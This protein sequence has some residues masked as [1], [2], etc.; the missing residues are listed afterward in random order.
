MPLETPAVSDFDWRVTPLSPGDSPHRYR[1]LYAFAATNLNLATMLW[2]IANYLCDPGD[3]ETRNLAAE[4]IYAGTLEPIS[5]PDRDGVTALR[6]SMHAA[7]ALFTI[8]HQ[9]ATRSR[10]LARRS[11]RFPRYFITRRVEDRLFRSDYGDFLEEEV[12]PGAMAI[13]AGALQLRDQALGALRPPATEVEQT[14]APTGVEL[15]LRGSPE[16]VAQQLAGGEEPERRAIIAWLDDQRTLSYRL[17]F[18]LACYHSRESGNRAGGE[19]DPD[20]LNLALSD[21]EQSLQGC[22]PE[23][24]RGIAEQAWNDPALAALRLNRREAFLR[25]VASVTPDI[26]FPAPEGHPELAPQGEIPAPLVVDAEVRERLNRH[27][28]FL[29]GQP[30]IVTRTQLI[31]DSASIMRV[32]ETM[33]TMAESDQRN[34]RMLLARLLFLPSWPAENCAAQEDGEKGQAGS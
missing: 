7:R 27:L 34:D 3:A 13:I 28:V 32:D 25:T 11:D 16:A 17:R 26:E 18:N 21:L 33:R 6:Q 30:P 2:F 8:S 19:L 31:S 12:R 24:Q 29:R 9:A 15:A 20:E 1:A 23:N 10:F 22:P 4:S 5:A 14:V